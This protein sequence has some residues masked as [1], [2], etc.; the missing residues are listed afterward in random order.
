MVVGDATGEVVVVVGEGALVGA[1]VLPP[2]GLLVVGAV[3]VGAAVTG[4][5]IGGGLLL[6]VSSTRSMKSYG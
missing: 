5:K 3:G 2:V 1:A 4:E 6:N